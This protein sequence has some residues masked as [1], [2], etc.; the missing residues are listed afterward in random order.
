MSKSVIVMFLFFD[1]M[2]MAFFE[3][4]FWNHR[5]CYITCPVNGFW[6]LQALYKIIG[7][8]Q[9]LPYTLVTWT[10]VLGKNRSHSS[11]T[12]ASRLFWRTLSG[13][14]NLLILPPSWV[15]MLYHYYYWKLRRSTSPQK[16]A[17]PQTTNFENILVNIFS[18]LV[19]FIL[20]IMLHNIYDKIE[21][22]RCLNYFIL[23]IMFF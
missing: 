20:R 5:V 23:F 11:N 7:G 18:W 2:F 21:V 13:N 15:H 1:R 14:N 16:C 17:I 6:F 19:L 3:C 9:Y 22:V 12:D 8:T 10:P 4:T